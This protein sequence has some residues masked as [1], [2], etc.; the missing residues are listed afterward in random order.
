[1]TLF[2]ARDE[3]DVL[4]T[5]AWAV[6]EQNPLEVICGGTC[7]PWTAVGL[8]QLNMSALAGIH[9]YEFEELVLAPGQGP[10]ARRLQALDAANQMMAFEPVDLG[11]IYGRRP[12][13]AASVAFS[14]VTWRGLG[15]RSVRRAT[16]CWA[17]ARSAGAVR[18]S[19]P[20]AG[21][22]KTSPATIYRN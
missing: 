3:Q 13:R 20:A 2:Q 12:A 9:L 16:I 4:D 19:S 14:P 8:G 22:S 11:P 15:A 5:V 18:F 1:M 21:W 10:R 7:A 17:F 6:A